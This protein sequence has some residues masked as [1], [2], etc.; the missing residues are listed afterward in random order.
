MKYFCGV[1]YL[2]IESIRLINFRNYGSLNIKLNKQINIFIGN[3]AQGKTNLLEAIYMCATG[4]SFRTNRDREIIN[5]NKKEAYIGANIKI[6]SY[7]RFIELK[8]ER[9]NP[10]TIRVNKIAL[11]NYKELNSGLNVVVFSPDDL[12]LVKDGP[13]ERRNF[14]DLSISQ[15]KPVYKHNLNRY[16]KI[17]F[18]RNNLLKSKKQKSE[19]ISLLEIFDLQLANIG[20]EI[21][22]E[23]MKFIKELS[24][25]AK[26]IHSNLT[27]KKENL[28]LEYISNIDLAKKDKSNIEKNFLKKIKLNLDR[29]FKIGTTGIGPHRDD[30]QIKINN[31]DARTYGS[32]GQQRTIVL[33]LK[34]SEVEIIKKDRGT[35]PVLLLD[36]VFSELDGDRRKYLTRSFNN[37]QTIITSTDILDLD[38]LNDIGK[39]TFYI[40]NGELVEIKE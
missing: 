34:L 6:N 11:K 26:A 28:S 23:R 18:Q 19:I 27:F 40:E 14:L 16:N 15:I 2:N 5:L 3:N 24:I 7:E 35:Y 10:K 33:S 29:D 12:K 39:S 9:D 30:M 25:M 32:Q 8:M 36:D 37:M 38:K 1:L 22:L 13:G 4:R 31:I 20:T 17:L 21:I